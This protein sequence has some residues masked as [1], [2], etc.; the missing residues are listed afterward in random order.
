M[1]KSVEI[2]GLPVISIVEG[3]E[4]GTVK[5]LLINPADGSVT[6]LIDDSKWYWGAKFLPLAAATG[7]GEYAITIENSDAILTL[8]DAPEVE[9]LIVADLKI[10]GTKVLTKNGRI[11]G[12]VTEFF[13]DNSG[14]IVSCE[15]EDLNGGTTSIEAKQILTFGKDVLFVSDDHETVAERSTTTNIAIPP[16]STSV[17]SEVKPPVIQVKEPED[18]KVAANDDS[19]RKFDEKNRKYLLGKKASRRIETDNGMLIV[20]EGGEITEEVLQ[21]A[22]LTGSFVE[23]TMNIQ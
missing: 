19:A 16:V 20:E 21:K 3:T 6:I 5:S 7:L 1:K 9:K 13:V 12:K 15:I 2:I 17:A 23:L 10:I 18:V 4:L 14:K 11:Q 8:T 22:K